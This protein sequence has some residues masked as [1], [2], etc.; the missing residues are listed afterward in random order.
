MPSLEALGLQEE[1]WTEKDGE[2]DSYTPKSDTTD[3]LLEPSCTTLIRAL[4]QGLLA[5]KTSIGM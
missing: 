5:L 1:T 3:R 4:R 2:H